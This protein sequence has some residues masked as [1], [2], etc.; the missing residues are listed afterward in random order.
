MNG[1]IR[2]LALGVF[3]AMGALLLTVT[4][5]QV[6]QADDLRSDPRNPRPALSERGKERG[7]I[8][9]ADGTI[10]AESVQRDD[11]RGFERVYPLG[12]V[13]AHTVGYTSLL[14]G[15]SGLEAVYAD[16]LRSRRDLT[17]SDL[18]AAVLGRDLRPESIEIT[19]DTELQATAFEA[20]GQNRG[21]VVALDPRTGAL[22]ALVSKPSFDPEALSADDATDYR[23]SL[24][25]D[26]A[27]PLIDRATKELFPPGS[28]FKTV[29]TATAI[30]TGFAEPSTEFDDPAELELPG[31]TATISNFDDRPC[32]NGTT[33]TLLQAFVRSCN[34][35]FASLAMQLGAE[36]I[37]ITSEALGFNQELDFAWTVP[38]AVW[39]TEELS[40]DLAAL[41]QSGIGERNVRATP[42]HM[43]MVAATIANG[44]VTPEP[45]IVQRVFDADGQ[46]VDEAT[47]SELGRAMGPE[48]ASLIAQ[49]MERVVTGGTGR[50]AAVPEV[51]VAGKTGTAEG[52]SGFPHS[53]FIGFA[54]VDAPSIA[55]AVLVEGSP[56]AGENASGGTVA[57]PIASDVFETW[58]ADQP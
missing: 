34:T 55:I 23:E 30:D 22:L 51:R 10:V 2:R 47:P 1:P 33:A 24:L 16:E 4:W 17:I 42:L 44:G 7:V 3:G 53:W 25:E 21:A 46:T 58:L 35:I 54:P 20:L 39:P 50:R 14:A 43:A 32:N 29:V 28:T 40:Q 8:V 15:S 56:A 48:T 52:P 13:F 26:E 27:R 9:T 36:E 12:E 18:L 38:E 37:A 11:Q 45:Y 19:I 41:A 5:F 31:S 6:V 57:A 49:M